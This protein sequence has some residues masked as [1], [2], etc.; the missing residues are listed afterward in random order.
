MAKWVLETDIVGS[1]ITTSAAPAYAVFSIGLRPITIGCSSGTRCPVSKISV[2]ID[3]GLVAVDVIEGLTS[4]GV[5][6][7]EAIVGALG[8]GEVGADRG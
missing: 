8:P 5:C 7:G 6:E 3:I 1:V 2:G 4:D